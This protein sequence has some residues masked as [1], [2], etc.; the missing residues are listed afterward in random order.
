MVKPTIDYYANI[1]T[2]MEKNVKAYDETL[3]RKKKMK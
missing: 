2:Y 1:N 3:S